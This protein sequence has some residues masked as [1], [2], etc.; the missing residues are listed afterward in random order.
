M[1]FLDDTDIVLNSLTVWIDT[2]HQNSGMYD[3]NKYRGVTTYNLV[4]EPLVCP[5]RR[6]W[7]KPQRRR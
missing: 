3:T 6:W 1:A 2:S 7:G 4:S 5:L